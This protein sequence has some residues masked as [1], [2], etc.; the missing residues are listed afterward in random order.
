MS[1]A[2]SPS[3]IPAPPPSL[4]SMVRRAVFR[5]ECPSCEGLLTVDGECLHCPDD[6]GFNVCS[7]CQSDLDV[8][9]HTREC[10][11]DGEDDGCD[12]DR[13]HDERFS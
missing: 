6:A 3:L 4:C 13:I 8:E 5:P 9:R 1:N 10:R 12:P 11:I 7:D 2:A